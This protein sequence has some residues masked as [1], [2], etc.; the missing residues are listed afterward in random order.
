LREGV[1]RISPHIYNTEH[2]VLR[3]IAAMST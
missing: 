3:L 2:D 1:L